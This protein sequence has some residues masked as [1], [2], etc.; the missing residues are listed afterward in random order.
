MID[1]ALLT[2]MTFAVFQ[3]ILVSNF[4]KKTEHYW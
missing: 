1:G 4:R 3:T 2:S